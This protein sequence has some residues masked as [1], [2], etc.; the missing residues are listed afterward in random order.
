MTTT[1]SLANWT[2]VPV[3]ALRQSQT[4]VMLTGRLAMRSLVRRRQR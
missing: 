1:T 3:F 2:F 4:C